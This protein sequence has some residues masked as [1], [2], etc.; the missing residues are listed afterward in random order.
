[1]ARTVEQIQ[2]DIDAVRA[3][4]AQGEVSVRNADGSGVDG[5]SEADRARALAALEQ[6]L[7]SATIVA[8]GGRKRRVYA[9]FPRTGY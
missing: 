9:M 2:A 8:S 6:E 1:M 4:A 5:R 7:A 3:Q